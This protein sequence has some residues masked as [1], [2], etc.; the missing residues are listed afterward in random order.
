VLENPK[1]PVLVFDVGGSHI[2]ASAFDSQDMAV[3]PAH[4]VSLSATASLSEFLDKIALLVRRTVPGAVSPIGASVA[5]PNPFDYA[6]GISYMQHKYR[7]LYGIDLRGRLSQ[8]LACEPESVHFL[9]DAAAFLMGEL[10][11]GAGFGVN[12]VVGITLGTGVGSAFASGGEIVTEGDGVPAGG[13]I[14]NLSY[15]DGIVEKFVSTLAIQEHYKLRTGILEDVQMIAHRS[16]TNQEARQTFEQ[17]GKELGRVLRTTCV[18]FGPERIIL[19]GGISRSAAL[20]L[21]LAEQ[22]LT[23]L[24]MELCVTQLG[25]RAPLIGAAVDWMKSHN[26]ISEL[27]DSIRDTEEA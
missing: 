14:W 13:E 16:E 27:R 7:C 17:F 25:E 9:N 11:R 20:F 6:R 1:G 12:R 10:Q 3:S 22:Q 15:K 26:D 5:M 24:G 8:L 18:G 4:S 21:P 19:G 2:T 23:G